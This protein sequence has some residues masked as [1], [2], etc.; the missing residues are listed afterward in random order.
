MVLSCLPL[1]GKICIYLFIIDQ[2]WYLVAYYRGH[3][4][5]NSFIIQSHDASTCFKLDIIFF[6]TIRQLY[7]YEMINCDCL[8]DLVF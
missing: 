7:M 2:I 1:V 5:L 4:A 6:I 8:R 3:F